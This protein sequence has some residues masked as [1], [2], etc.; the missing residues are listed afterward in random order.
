MEDTKYLIVLAAA[1][2]CICFFL[3]AC[4]SKTYTPDNLPS[5]Q[6]T[7]GEGGGFTGKYT[8]WLLTDSGQIFEKSGLEGR[9]AEKGRIKKSAAKK[10]YDRAESIPP[11]KMKRNEPGNYNYTLARQRDST[12]LVAT[13]S[14]EAQIDSTI[15]NLY[16]ELR[17]AAKG[18]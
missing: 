3:W 6:L 18:F 13:W 1:A 12:E 10:F 17:S 4:N 14:N 11:A 7:F 16:K 9:Y 15:V 5:R 8:T 2:V